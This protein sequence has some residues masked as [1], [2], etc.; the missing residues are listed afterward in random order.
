MTARVV[1]FTG[2]SYVV[3]FANIMPTKLPLANYKDLRVATVSEWG[4]I[5]TV[6]R[7]PSFYI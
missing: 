1:Q 3:S 2:A 6:K 7:L 5:C 4:Q